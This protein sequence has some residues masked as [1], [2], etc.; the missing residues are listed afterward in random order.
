MTPSSE[1][2]P[3][4]LSLRAATQDD[5]LAATRLL[6]SLGLALPEDDDDARAH[7]ARL[8]RDNPGMALASSLGRVPSLGW[9]LES[10]PRMVGFFGNI[11][12]AYS[13]GAEPVL[14]A[15][16]SQWGVLREHR[17]DTA[18]LADAYFA[19]EGA[20]ALLVTSA[21]APTGRI[22]ER[23]GGTR[24]PV[25]E[26]DRVLLWITRARGFVAAALRRKG[27]PMAAASAAAFVAGPVLDASLRLSGRRPVASRTSAS[28]RIDQVAVSDVDDSFDALWRAVIAGPVR[29]RAMRDAA[30][31]RWHFGA[32]AAAGRASLL[33]AR[34]AGG[35][36][37]VLSGYIALTR[38]DV[39]AIGLT[40]LRVADI[41]LRDERDEQTLEA[42]L[43]AAIDEARLSGCDVIEL[44]G[45]GSAW[46][47]Q[48]R[49]LRPLTRA[50]P[51]W[52]A[53]DKALRPD[54]MESLRHEAAWLPSPYDGDSAL[55]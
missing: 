36:S 20:D 55:F 24:I 27:V 16:A 22:F 3:S 21:I 18:R 38:E 54:L 23:H 28:A 50:L 31:V 52:P 25:P 39:P 15:V 5:A 2:L 45:L 13:W 47:A 49:T 17:S 14:V 48:A 11:P 51:T 7:W 37:A 35:S 9:V 30:H 44:V 32:L 53:F 6:R 43:R 42:L 41:V 34:D 46:R 10:G 4:P 40:R 19:Q 1:V 12:M 29:L 26:Q 33:V 8:W